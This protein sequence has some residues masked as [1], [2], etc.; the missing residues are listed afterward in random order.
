MVPARRETLEIQAATKAAFSFMLRPIQ[1][2]PIGTG[3]RCE[4]FLAG[5]R[6]L[7]AAFRQRIFAF[8]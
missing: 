2:S 5:M 4:T 1:E 6:R 3:D 7:R 8:S